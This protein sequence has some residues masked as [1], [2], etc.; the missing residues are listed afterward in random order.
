MTMNF[1]VDRDVGIDRLQSGQRIHFSMS[2]DADGNWVIRTIHVMD[3][4]AE[5]GE[6]PHD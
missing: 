1:A 6:P 4:D 2:R 5:T 3:A